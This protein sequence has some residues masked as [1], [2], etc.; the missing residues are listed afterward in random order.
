MNAYSHAHART[1]VL[2]LWEGAAALSQLDEVDV[3][4]VGGGN[5]VGMMT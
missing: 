5:A 4:L 1:S 3:F 2:T